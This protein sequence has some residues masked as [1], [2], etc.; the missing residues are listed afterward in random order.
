[1]VF[2]VLESLV[3]QI[4]AELF[5]LWETLAFLCRTS[6]YRKSLHW[7]FDLRNVIFALAFGLVRSLYLWPSLAA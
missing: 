3:R 1:M 2:V 5:S 7:L 6:I 4:R